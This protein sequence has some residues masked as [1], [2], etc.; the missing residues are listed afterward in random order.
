MERKMSDPGR[1]KYRNPTTLTLVSGDQY[2]R[3]PRP[4]TRRAMTSGEYTLESALRTAFAS[5]AGADGTVPS[6]AIYD[7][8]RGRQHPW[9]T[10]ARR[11]VEMREAG[12]SE[13]QA[14]LII[15]T[16]K[17]WITTRLY[18]ASRKPAA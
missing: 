15:D 4:Q 14:H 8:R 16:F 7:I 2:G 3:R 11:L 17:W 18:R 5:V 13:D 9:R 12:A 1:G 6:E 10:L